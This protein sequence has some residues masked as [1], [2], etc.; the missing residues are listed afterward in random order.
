MLILL[1]FLAVWCQGQTN[2]CQVLCDNNTDLNDCNQV[3][4]SAIA[5][6]SLYGE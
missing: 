6:G 3:G 1:L 5:D 4:S 2:T